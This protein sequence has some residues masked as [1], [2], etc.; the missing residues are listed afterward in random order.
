VQSPA[1][2]CSLSL[3]HLHL[4]LD[5]LNLVLPDRDV[6]LETGRPDPTVGFPA[7]TASVLPLRWTMTSRSGRPCHDSGPYRSGESGEPTVATARPVQGA[8]SGLARQDSENRGPGASAAMEGRTNW[9][10]S[11]LAEPSSAQARWRE[12]R[13]SRVSVLEHLA[14]SRRFARFPIRTGAIYP[15]S[16]LRKA[17]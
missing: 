8:T 2:S 16:W 15:D 13:P 17:Q 6:A 9:R 14:G 12:R 1:R 3:Q 7:F 5:F 4:G 10:G 11:A